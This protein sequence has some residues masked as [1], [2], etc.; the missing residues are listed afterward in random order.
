M[1][2]NKAWRRS[3]RKRKLTPNQMMTNQLSKKMRREKPKEK[4]EKKERK[5]RKVSNRSRFPK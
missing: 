5:T 4:K 1:K 3:K 2:L